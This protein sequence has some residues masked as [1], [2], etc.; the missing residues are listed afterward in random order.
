MKPI[1]DLRARFI[2]ERP[3]YEAVASKV[4]SKIEAGARDLGL[5]LQFEHRAKDV[6]SLVKKALL[7]QLEYEQIPD[8]AG[9]R[10]IYAYEWERL[11]IEDLVS[12]GF[13]VLARE[14]MGEA[15]EPNQLDYLGIHYD[16]R[17]T[18]Q[19]I[20][21]LGSVPADP[22]CEVQLHTW[23]Q[24]VWARYSHE[25]LYKVQFDPPRPVSR[26][27][28]RLLAMVELFDQE[29]N[30]A[31]TRILEEPGY[32][33][34]RALARLEREFFKNL[35]Q[36]Y[37]A[38][39]T[40]V[41]LGAVLPLFEDRA[42]DTVIGEFI[43]SQ[44]AKLERLYSIY[45]TDPRATPLLFQ[46]ESIL[47]LAALDEMPTALKSVFASVAPLEL[48]DELAIAWGDPLE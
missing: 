13:V 36:D 26:S 4:R 20:A 17:L 14:D 2:D 27:L 10:V 11:A 37:D 9:V 18:E 25:L 39:L 22:S 19:D 8:K 43:A 31:R 24:N 46:P 32:E 45:R 44:G 47:L 34:A 16:V 30:V 23:Q 12:E 40:Q 21:D 33:V 48:L 29:V 7:H 5:R 3:Y 1:E 41:I 6:P 35:A 38:N 28:H 15:L 42:I